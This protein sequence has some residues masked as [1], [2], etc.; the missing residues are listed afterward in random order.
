MKKYLLIMLA[1]LPMVFTACSSDDDDSTTS[2]LIG[3]TWENVEEVNGVVESKTT[4]SFTTSSSV[5]V[6]VDGDY[7]GQSGFETHNTTTANYSI[8]GDRV[9]INLGNKTTKGTIG[10]NIITFTDID[11][12]V[13]TIFK[14]K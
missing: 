10:N 12:G 3:T 6:T 1:F 9:T 14:K 2:Q 11:G 8:S 7:D 4:L 5:T 13:T